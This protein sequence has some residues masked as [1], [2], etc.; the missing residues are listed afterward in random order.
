MGSFGTAAKYLLDVYHVEPLWLIDVREF[1]SA[2]L[3]LGAATVVDRKRL[4]QA[5][6]DRQALGK[7]FQ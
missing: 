1:F 3:F 4:T 5:M 7:I 6:H 2:L